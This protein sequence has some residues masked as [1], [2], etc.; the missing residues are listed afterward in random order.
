M[1]RLCVVISVSDGMIF[2]SA[3]LVSS[4]NKLK[5][6]LESSVSKDHDTVSKPSE[7]DGLEQN[8]STERVPGISVESSELDSLPEKL[9]KL[10]DQLVHRLD[11]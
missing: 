5:T 6:R 4:L 1:F 3:D 8:R 9:L 7:S 10:V 11:R 2:L